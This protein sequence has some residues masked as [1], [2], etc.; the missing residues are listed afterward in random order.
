MSR[1]EQLSSAELLGLVSDRRWF[2]AAGHEPE[3]AHVL[4]LVFA[5]EEL[6]LAL[7]DV[8][9]SEA[10]HNTYLVAIGPGNDDAITHLPA[11]ARL[12]ALAGYETP[13]T[14]S[15]VMG[16]EQSN[17]SVVIDESVVLK[18][19]RRLEA[20]PSPEVEMLRVLEAAGFDSAPRLLGAIEHDR[21]PLEATLAVLTEYV[22]SAGGGWELALA[23]LE[24]DDLGW[25]PARARR[26]GEV[27]GSM[28]AALAASS[29]PYMAPE[30]ASSEAIGLLAA[31]VDEEVSRLAADLPLLADTS[32]GARVEDLRDLIQDLSHVGPPG[33]VVRIHG[34]YHLGQV[35]WA[36]T[37]DW[38]V[39]DFE[40]EPGRSLT[41]RR[42]RTFALRDVAGMLRSFAYAADASRL[43][44]KVPSPAGWEESC[45]SAFVEGWR[46]TVDPRLLP[47]SEPGLDRLLALFELQ[48][49]VYELRYELANRPDWVGIPVAGLERMLEG[50]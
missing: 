8:R 23:S 15:R 3:S 10:M 42:R 21:E 30:E 25:L 9:F 32:L 43:L 31:T 11:L 17:S 12:V 39:I 4:R 40:G 47:S 29:D 20:G 36:D 48:K 41:E 22:P 33:L 46:A 6:E 38:V 18:L 45:R 24:A 35:L 16:V 5:D 19:Y 28:H 34:D 27:T 2:G 26:L 7:V 50:A 37:G 13:C 49:L 1:I 14:S 44:A